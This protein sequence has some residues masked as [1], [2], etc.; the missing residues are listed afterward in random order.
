MEKLIATKGKLFFNSS[1]I[2][3][4]NVHYKTLKL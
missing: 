1:D 3:K 2:Y 4:I